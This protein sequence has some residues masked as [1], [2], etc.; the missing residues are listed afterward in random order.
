MHREVQFET[1]MCIPTYFIFSRSQNVD[2]TKME[3]I[4]EWKLQDL[5]VTLPL[6]LQKT[7]NYHL[8]EEK[9]EK[10]YRQYDILFVFGH[11]HKIKMNVL[12]QVMNAMKLEVFFTFHLMKNLKFGKQQCTSANIHHTSVAILKSTG[13][14]EAGCKWT[15]SGVNVEC[16]K[17]LG[18][19]R[20]KWRLQT[21]I[22]RLLITVVH[23]YFSIGPDY[24]TYLI[25]RV[26]V[27]RQDLH[28]APMN[29]RVAPN[30]P[31]HS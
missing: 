6:R 23:Q 19:H 13:S 26:I 22:Q 16:S 31:D 5:L 4:G 7:F 20:W 25:D 17:Y 9:K 24:P 8:R 2:F 28:H 1:S 27:D 30:R 29:L 21:S 14:S 12:E 10:D 3:A 11:R 18:A 15:H